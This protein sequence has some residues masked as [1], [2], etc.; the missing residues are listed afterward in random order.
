[1]ETLWSDIRF[2]LRML[3]KKPGF[4]AVAI[5]TL[6]LG[7]GA[8]TS[9]FTVVD[10]VLLRPLPFPQPDRLAQLVE[11]S[12]KGD[13]MNVPEA[14]FADWKQQSRSFQHIAA[15]SGTQTVTITGGREPIRA[16]YVLVSQGFF[17]VLGVQPH[18]G[19]TLSLQ[20]HGRGASPVA[21]ISHEF[22]QRQFN[23][24]T[25]LDNLT[26]RYGSF[27]FP[28]VGVMPPGFRYPRDADLWAPMEAFGQFNPSRSAHNW[29]VFGRLKPG[30][31]AAEA[32]AELSGIAKRIHQ[33]YTD[34][35]AVDATVVP[36]QEQIT[37]RVRP[38]L[39][40]MLGAVGA[41]L[42][43]AC[44]NVTNLL[45]AQ[46]TVRERELALR[47]AL[48]ASR[49]RLLR[50]SVTESVVLTA[51]GAALGILLA[52]WGVDTMLAQASSQLPRGDEIAVD[53][54]VFFFAVALSLL[55]GLVLGILPALRTTE[56][57]LQDVLREGGRSQSGAA[58]HRLARSGLV[59]AQIGMTLI[60]LVAAGLLARSFWQT[61]QVDLGFEAGRQLALDLILPGPNTPED[62]QELFRF[63]REL[64]ARIAA[65]PGVT[66]SG[67]INYLPLS[68]RSSNGRFLIE[69]G[70]D[71]GDLWPN[72][73]VA[74]PGYFAAMGIPLLSGR[75][76]D[77]RDDS[78]SPHV[79]VISRTVADRVW[80]GANPLGQRINYGNMDGDDQH[81]VTIIG[82]VGDIRHNGPEYAT[83]GDIYLHYL[84]R[85]QTIPT[86]TTVIRTTG[87]P[88][89]LIAA[90]RGL[91]R[92]L[93]PE[94][95][96]TFRT[97]SEYFS[98]T[99]A[100]RRF[101]LTLVAVFGGTALLLAV[102]G[103]YGVM[104][105]TVAQRT[106]EIGIRMALGARGADVVGQFL[107][108][109]GALVVIGLALGLGGAAALSQYISSLLYNTSVRDPLT[110]AAVAAALATVAMLACWIPARRAT[111]VDP[112]VAL[113][114]E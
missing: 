59:V 35:T 20:E 86:F 2:S 60:L 14:N 9:I 63:H 34:V 42:L 33:Q 78:Q 72:Y 84:Q 54:R 69:G 4:T 61:L 44:A 75:W 79:A 76:F 70:S 50:Q 82:I 56:A 91:V 93:N 97:L 40:V 55:T 16:A 104:A 10:A 28:V 43:I 37:G 48:G 83:R 88:R 64:Q 17:D 80:P 53:A 18:L 101:N 19:R 99:L 47:S 62:Q 13:R 7:I 25:N 11:I 106:Q 94:L 39:L 52:T 31:S 15:Y 12:D 114:H 85:P 32:G 112:M 71:S 102:M 46:A 98:F 73:R 57:N 3:A 30:V 1:M 21:V 29:R 77:S 105:Y 27:N 22:W 81:W 6:A 74:S 67:G 89:A 110:F 49:T 68:G 109:G 95:P 108:E 8:C 87:D 96:M 51:L 38:A 36:L 65:L 23:A 113:R 41:L 107:R 92:E 45:L 103:M 66:A 24:D 90:V 100:N 58:R 26:L 5:L 111:R